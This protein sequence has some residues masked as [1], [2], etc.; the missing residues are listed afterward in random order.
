MQ[1]I[2][3]EIKSLKI[4]TETTSYELSGFDPK[5]VFIEKT[6]TVTNGKSSTT[7]SIKPGTKAPK[8]YHPRF[9]KPE[10]FEYI[11]THHAFDS[12]DKH[13]E[14]LFVDV[15]DPDQITED[16]VFIWDCDYDH[17]MMDKDKNFIPYCKTYDYAEGP[18]HNGEV[19]LNEEFIQFL[20]QHP[21]VVN[22][23]S[24]E[25]TDIPHYNRDGKRNKTV[26]VKILPDVDTYNEIMNDKT[27]RED[28]ARVITSKR[29]VWDIKCKDYFGIRPFLK[30][31]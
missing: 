10:F 13:L 16:L 18:F 14:N 25:I 17:T 9:V 30:N 1:L 27:L 20:K 29:C 28:E 4:E 26:V 15:T 7:W 24:L 2:Q 23:D 5:E 6:V 22:K 3:T 8:R 19:H 12:Y 31:Q 11:K 21:W